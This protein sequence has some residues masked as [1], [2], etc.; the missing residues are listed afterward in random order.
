MTSQAPATT[1]RPTAREVRLRRLTAV[2]RRMIDGLQAALPSPE[3]RGAPGALAALRRSAG[4]RPGESLE[5]CAI[6]E[7]FVPEDLSA[8]LTPLEREALYTVAALFAIHPVNWDR[9]DAAP[10]QGSR[11]DHHS[12]GASL[13]AIRWRESGEENPGVERRFIA[14]LDA[15]STAVPTHLR[16][17]VT[18]LKPANQPVDYVQLYRDIVSWEHP[19]REVQ[20]R[21]AQEFWAAPPQT[22]TSEQGNGSSTPGS[23]PTSK[24]E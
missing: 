14:L 1:Q 5:A 19:S 10:A 17:L 16:T 4:K 21:W 20:R 13:R 6:V 18:L 9:A 23:T 3:R 11:R 12:F 22:S 2:V 7:R 24:E 8:Q 15:D